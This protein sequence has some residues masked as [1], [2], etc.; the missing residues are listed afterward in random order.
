[1]IKT[2]IRY[3]V[4]SD[5]HLGHPRNTQSEIISALGVYFNGYTP[6]VDLD[7]L[8]FAGDVFD[9]LLPYPGVEES[10]IAVWIAEIFRFCEA[11]NCKLRVLEGT[12][13]HD[14]GQSAAFNTIHK[15]LKSKVDFKYI[16]V[17]CIEEMKDLDITVL[18]VPDEWSP[19]PERTYADVKKALKEANLEKADIAIMHGLFGF[20]LPRLQGRIPKHD[21]QS[22]LDVVRYLINIGHIHTSSVFERILA[23]GSFDR[24]SHGEEEV[25]GGMECVIRKDGTMAYYFIENKLSKSFRTVNLRVRDIDETIK[26]IERVAD[27]LRQGSYIRLRA[28]KDH[29]ALI[30]LAEVKRRF[31][32]FVITK[33]A[34]EDEEEI[35]SYNLVEDICADDDYIPITITESNIQALM[36]EAMMKHDLSVKKWEAF[37][38]IMNEVKQL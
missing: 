12:P 31:P 8:F 38:V 3:A 22:Y 15:A 21:E 14:R 13:S 34:I 35:Q 32:A 27:K 4:L 1:M 20:Q 5:L 7:I 26:Q 28:K 9:Q 19:T 6:R 18:Y 29:P 11:S 10:E 16:D 17:L 36:M 30:A 37:N 25:K 2:E 33:I 24:L 23:Q